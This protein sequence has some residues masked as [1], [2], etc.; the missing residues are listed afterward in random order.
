MSAAPRFK[1]VVCGRAGV[2]KTSLLRATDPTWRLNDARPAP[3]TIGVDFF[4]RAIAASDGRLVELMF[5][6]TAGQERYAP[7]PRSVY[8]DA[9]AIVFVYDITRRD[10]FDAMATLLGTAL[11]AAGTP[12][13]H[14]IIVGAKLDLAATQRAVT[15]AEAED[16]CRARNYSL[17]ET[18]ARD[19][20]NVDAMLQALADALVLRVPTAPRSVTLHQ[21]PPRLAG[22]TILPP[23]PP[24]PS[25]CNC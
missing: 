5:W 13:P 25:A 4:T 6:D 1:V 7:P 3:A 8:R 18:S 2:G 12:E 17:L 21:P 22:A 9:H 23:S 15:V 10:S 19:R 24:P 14:V 20:T 11:A 16:G